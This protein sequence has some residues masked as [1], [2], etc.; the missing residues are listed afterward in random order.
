MR[1]SHT[2]KRAADFRLPPPG[3]NRW[4]AQRKAAVVFA[5]RLGSLSRERAQQLYSI[6]EEELVTW[7]DRFEV[8]GLGGLQLKSA[9][10]HKR[11][12]PRQNN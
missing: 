10:I 1:I 3:Y 5:V 4:T 6:S 12:G 11:K 7:E 9:P 2:P 8:D